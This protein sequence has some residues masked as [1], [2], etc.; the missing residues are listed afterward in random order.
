LARHVLQMHAVRPRFQ[1]DPVDGYT[2]ALKT[3]GS[4]PAARLDE[5]WLPNRNRIFVLGL[6]RRRG[7]NHRRRRA[8]R[9]GYGRGR[10]FCCHGYR[11]ALV[12][13]GPAGRNHAAPAEREPAPALAEPRARSLD[14]DLW[15]Q[16]TYLVW[17]PGIGRTLSNREPF[18][19]VGA[20]PTVGM[21]WSQVGADSTHFGFADGAWV[22]AGA[23]LVGPP[24]QCQSEDMRPYAA[25]IVGI[26]GGELYV[27]PKIGV[28]SVPHF[29][30]DLSGLG[31]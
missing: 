19:F 10:A 16:R 9:A 4:F 6:L 18:Q 21:R 25:L 30:L 29:C 8:Q 11:G 26:R 17:E 13:S 23:A 7:S 20:G 12:R 31:F 27:S 2:T 1:H 28:V 15:A 14:P 22:S 3:F 5:E 24:K